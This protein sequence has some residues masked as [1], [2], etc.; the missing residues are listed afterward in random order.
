MRLHCLIALLLV[1]AFL[2]CAHALGSQCSSPR[3]SIVASPYQPRLPIPNPPP[4][5]RICTVQSHGDGVS[6]DSAYI[7][8]AFHRCNDGGHVVF[9]EEAQPYVI[10]TAMDWTFLSSIDIGTCSGI[11]RHIG[12]FSWHR[13]ENELTPC[14]CTEIRG[15]ILFTPDTDY[16][17]AKSFRFIFQNV[18]SFFK[19]G[20]DDVWIYGGECD[21]WCTQAAGYH[22]PDTA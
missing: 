10:G 7:L 22:C 6:D 2:N 19:L 16:W 18:T 15:K 13:Y 20:G 12:R 17:Q 21:N 11:T 8:D 4:R 1:G 9:T 3:P 14:C 5:S